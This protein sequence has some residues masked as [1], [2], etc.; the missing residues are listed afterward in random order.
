MDSYTVNL[1]VLSMVFS[2]FMHAFRIIVCIWTAEYYHV[3]SGTSFIDG[4][5]EGYSEFLDFWTVVLNVAMNIHLQSFS[6]IIFYPLTIYLWA[7]CVR[8][9]THI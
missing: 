4:S 3:Y 6:F 8:A 9:H 1:F 2:R 7:V 5:V